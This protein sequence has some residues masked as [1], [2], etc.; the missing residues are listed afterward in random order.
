M[1]LDFEM[2]QSTKPSGHD[3]AQH[4]QQT[5]SCM[6]PDT[7]IEPLKWLS[8]TSSLETVGLLANIPNG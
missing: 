6:K 2:S 3:T 5:F 7:Y 1:R 8:L 4:S